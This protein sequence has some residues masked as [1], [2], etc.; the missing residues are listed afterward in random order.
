MKKDA[1]PFGVGFLFEMS[2]MVFEIER[3]VQVLLNVR[4]KKPVVHAMTNWVTA[5]E[6]ASCLYAIGARAIMAIASEEAEEITAKA[7]A[8]VLNLGT[9]SSRR[10]EAMLRSGHRANRDGHPILFDP[11]GVSASKFRTE[12]ARRILSDLNITV[13]RGNGSEIGALAGREGHMAGVDA[14]PSGSE[15]GD[16]PAQDLCKKT[17]AIVIAS[18]PEDLIVSSMSQVRV[19]NGHPMM[20]QVP[21][22]GCMLTAVIGA[23]NAVEKDP[24][25]ASVSGVAFFGLAGERAALMTKGPGTFKSAFLDALYSLTIDQMRKG[26]KIR[27]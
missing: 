1:D 24:M 12:S 22:M 27:S 5:N 25:I 16:Q 26:I 18:G 4:E 8:L 19:G 15:D 17:G 3:L 14:A 11:V 9:P 2:E 20:S 6:V 21:G 13:I 23:F 10:I 7:D